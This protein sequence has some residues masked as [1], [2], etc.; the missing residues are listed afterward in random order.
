MPNLIPLRHG[1]RCMPRIKRSIVRWCFRVC[2]YCGPVVRDAPTIGWQNGTQWKYYA[3]W[4]LSHKLISGNPDVAHA[5]TNKFLRN[6][7]R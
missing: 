2:A 7:V 5:F 6:G 3:R 1:M 4:L